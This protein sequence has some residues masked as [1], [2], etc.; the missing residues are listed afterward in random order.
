MKKLQ[1]CKRSHG[2]VASGT[3]YLVMI[4]SLLVELKKRLKAYDDISKTSGFFSELT[5]LSIEQIE[6]KAKNIV[7]LYPDYLEDMV[8]ELIQLAAIMRTQKPATVNESAQLAMYKLSSS[9]NLSQT[10]PN[11]EIALRIYLCMMVCN[12]SNERSFS[13]LG[14]VKGE[15]WSSVGQ[16][17]L[18]MLTLMSTEHLDFTDTIEEFA[19]AKARKTAICL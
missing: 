14:I 16:E 4:N 5:S 8:T 6:D 15:L 7:S 2:K 10:F 11:V 13:K 12:A 17:M 1:S 9:L 19:L 3:R 18:S